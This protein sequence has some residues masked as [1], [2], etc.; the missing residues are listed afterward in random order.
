MNYLH[1]YASPLGGITLTSDG[2]ALTGLWF[3]GQK[4]FPHHL[5]ADSTEAELPVFTQTSQLTVRAAGMG[6]RKT[7]EPFS[8]RCSVME[9]SRGR[10]CSEFMVSFP[11]AGVNGRYGNGDGRASPA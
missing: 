4:H 2:E 10:A 7:R 8:R 5:T 9:S 11:Y 6:Q 1:H 3:G